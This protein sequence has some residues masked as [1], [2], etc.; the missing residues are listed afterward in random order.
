M[1]KKAWNH[2]ALLQIFKETFELI[3]TSHHL[4]KTLQKL[5]VT[6]LLAK[7][8][9]F[10]VLLFVDQ[11][12]KSLSLLI[13]S[14]DLALFG[15]TLYQNTL[16]LELDSRC[17]VGR[18]HQQGSWFRLGLGLR[19]SEEGRVTASPRPVE[20]SLM[21]GT[22]LFLSFFF[23]LADASTYEARTRASKKSERRLVWR[24]M[25]VDCLDGWFDQTK[26]PAEK[27]VQMAL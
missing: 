10:L 11:L 21:L 13:S 15:D 26:T 4:A 19:T 5:F 9:Y 20:L 8:S 23:F 25:M 1:R 16:I 27:F 6:H 14:R 12:F 18:V 2:L 17:S 22:F 7:F 3:K 24:R